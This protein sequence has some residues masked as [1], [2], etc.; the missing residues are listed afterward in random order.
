[1]K[2]FGHSVPM[3]PSQSP[4]SF[5]FKNLTDLL[6]LGEDLD[7]G[8]PISAYVATIL[9]AKYDGITNLHKSLTCKSI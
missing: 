3:K 2:W 1:M 8:E 9:E 5:Y 7:D 4:Q 6:Q